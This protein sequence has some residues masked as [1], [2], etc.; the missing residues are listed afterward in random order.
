M[1]KL[2]E[3]YKMGS[4]ELANRVVMAP[5]TRSRAIQNIPNDLM[6]EYYST[7]ATAGLL[8]TEGTS[9]SPNGLGY[10]RIPG[11]YSTEQIAGWKKVTS[12][13]HKNGGKIF[14]QMM[15]T[16]RVS[17][18]DNMPKGAQILA[19]SAVT[20]GGTM[21][22]DQN[23]PQPHP[24]PKEMTMAD[25]QQ[26]QNEYVQGSLNAIQAGFDGVELHA[27]NGY[28][29]DQFLRRWN[30]E[31][32][33]DAVIEELAKVD[34]LTAMIVHDQNVSPRIIANHVKKGIE[35]GREAN[36]PSQIIDFIPQHHGTRVLAY[37]YHKAKSLAEA[38]GE[39]VN[40]DDFR[41][42]GPKPQTREAVILMLADGAEAS[43]RSLEDQTPENIRAIVKKIVDTV[44]SDG[45][46]DESNITMRELTTIRESLINTLINVYHERISYPGFNPPGEKAAEAEKQ[47]PGPHD[48]EIAGAAAAIDDFRVGAREFDGLRLG[49]VGED[50]DAA[51]DFIRQT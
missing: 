10:A 38:R 39:T 45:Q 12:A 22:T 24:T 49:G 6:A 43:V 3:K 36:L 15:H 17:H 8:I 34:L 46:F 33:K 35:M 4:I 23:G 14:L 2:F 48:T 27:A 31:A 9:P 29:V 28:L 18:P 50:D 42:P 5:L 32:R 37:F 44:V 47:V 19:P 20:L 21:W 51:R 11:I 30:G 16:G 13:V 25:I 26:A 7:R 41:Y 1:K 40:I